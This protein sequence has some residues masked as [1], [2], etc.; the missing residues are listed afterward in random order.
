MK[1]RDLLNE[2]LDELAC[3]PAAKP[4]D[5]VSGFYLGQMENSLSPDKI[6]AAL[7]EPPAFQ[8]IS[9]T[10]A[11]IRLELDEPAERWNRNVFWEIEQSITVRKSRKL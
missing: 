10:Y 2:R 11:L 4:F 8:F 9:F 7:G 5:T 1:I 3:R 6:L